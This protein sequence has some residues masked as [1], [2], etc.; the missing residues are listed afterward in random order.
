MPISKPFQ[1]IRAGVLIT[2]ASVLAGCGV[3]SGTADLEQFVQ[4]TLSRTPGPIEPI[5]EFV[6]YEPFTYSAA[7][8]RSPF[9]SPLE[10]LLAEEDVRVQAVAP[11]ESRP[12]EF[13]EGMALSTLSMSGTI[14]RDGVRWKKENKLRLFFYPFWREQKI[15]YLQNHLLAPR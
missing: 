4:T 6:E 1:F 2:L 10:A 13:L 9:D 12:R 15:V 3:G 11:D 5:P 14:A 7:S 8:L